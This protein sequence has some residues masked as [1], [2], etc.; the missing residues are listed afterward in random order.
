MCIDDRPKGKKADAP[1]QPI[2]NLSG[3]RATDLSY[4]L[5]SLAREK[6][7]AFPF[8]LSHIRMR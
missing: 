2:G 6:D 7:K 5:P 1:I 8:R 4:A 3:T